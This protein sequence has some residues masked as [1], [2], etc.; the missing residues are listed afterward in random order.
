[1]ANKKFSEFELKTTTS[2]VSHVVGYDGVENVRITPAN[3]L[4][5]TGGPYLP[6]AGGT[7]TGNTIHNDNVKSI[8]GSPGNDLEIYHDGSNSI[9]KDGGLGN[10]YVYSDQFIINNFPDTQNMARFVSGGAATL[11]YNGV[12]KFATTSTGISVTG[13]GVFTGNVDIGA[14]TG[15][16]KLNVD[17]VSEGDSYFQG[18]T[19]NAR[20]LKFSTFATISPHAGHKINAT[21]SNGEIA[22]ATGGTERIRLNSAGN[23]GIGTTSP[24][25]LLSIQSDNAT[26]YDSSVDDGQDGEGA[27][28]MAFNTDSTTTNSFSQLL[29]R[30]RS[31]G[32]AISRIVS[33]SVAS[34]TTDLA[35]V[36]ENSN[37]KAEK[38]R[39][40]GAG[41]VG[42]GTSTPYA[43]LHI[44]DTNGGTIYIEDSDSSST[45]NITSISNSGSN[46]SFDT[47]SSTGTYV[48]T[49][50]QIVKN[51][52]GTDYHR[53]F[54]QASE[55]MRLTS[56]GVVGI[57]TTGAFSF[58]T[59][60]QSGVFIQPS[61]YM[62]ISVPSGIT[63]ALILR[64]LE[65]GSLV[66]FYNSNNAVGN[67]SVAGSTTVYSTSSDYRL[68]EDL[69]DFKGLDLV[70]KIPVYDY[71][72]KSSNDRGYGVMAH[73][74]QEVLPQAVTGD[75]DAEEMQS[76]DY[77]KIVPLLVKS[78]QELKA[79]I[80]LLKNK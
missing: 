17:S 29:F 67:I 61:S 5:T 18:G 49:D 8:Y 53:W 66:R 25:S 10:L 24:L 7:M 21:S 75:K 51:S 2:N 56:S 37:V 68:K 65:D 59:G 74:L 11:Y 27:T 36:T 60:S 48:S 9:I 28:I 15:T 79:E 58:G 78:I 35:F 32:V 20:Q 26:A 69:Q 34:G 76:V 33:L 54:T 31:S 6:L 80:E 14:V 47:R 62:G 4:D 77:S 23:L 16:A 71:K 50:Y 72:W 42:I 38:M 22:L 40:T 52:S 30:N 55:K 63:S 13:D 73:Q 3:F 70:S 57:G 39:I 43:R 41:N 46:V 44:S 45:Y 64:R 1:M 12:E 19:G